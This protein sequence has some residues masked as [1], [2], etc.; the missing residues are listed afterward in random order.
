MKNSLYISYLF[1]GL[2]TTAVNIGVYYLFTAMLGIPYLISNLLA[3]FISVT[4]AF[5]T[6]KY[7]VFDKSNKRGI[8]KEYMLFFSSRIFTGILDMG[9]MYLLVSLLSFDDVISKI[10]VNVFVIVA[11]FLIS[12][13]IIFK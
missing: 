8:I 3:W 6:N 1:W 12:K 10:L 11:N 7:F 4:F 5:F 2:L 13:H 9:M